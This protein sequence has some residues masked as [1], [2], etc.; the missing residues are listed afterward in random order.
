MRTDSHKRTEA[1]RQWKYLSETLAALNSFEALFWAIAFNF[2]TKRLRRYPSVTSAAPE[3]EASDQGRPLVGH[4]IPVSK[5]ASLP[6][7]WIGVLCRSIIRC[8]SMIIQSPGFTLQRD[9]GAFSSLIVHGDLPNAIGSW[10]RTLSSAGSTARSM[11][12]QAP[13]RALR[14]RK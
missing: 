14:V 6:I 1:V 4:T 3:H 9:A 5:M 8:Y 2:L 7:K 10:C 13:I 11:R 12:A